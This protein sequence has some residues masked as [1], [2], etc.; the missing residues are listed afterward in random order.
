M[1]HKGC[2]SGSRE[3]DMRFPLFLPLGGTA[4]PPSDDQGQ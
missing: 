4:V 3:H 2:P 1:G